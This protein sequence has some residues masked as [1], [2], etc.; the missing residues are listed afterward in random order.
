MSRCVQ[1]VNESNHISRS[2]LDHVHIHNELLIQVN[3][4]NKTADMCFSD[5]DALLFQFA[6][7]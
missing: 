3:T 2:L 7:V 5:Q 6:H 1:I 4:E